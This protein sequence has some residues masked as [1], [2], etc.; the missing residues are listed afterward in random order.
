MWYP[1]SGVVLDCIVSCSLASFLLRY[2]LLARYVPNLPPL[3]KH[4]ECLAH[5]VALLASVKLES[6]FN[7]S[8]EK[9]LIY[10]KDSLIY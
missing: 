2:I 5:I 8:T 10:M 6:P 9:M 1:G 3:F 7:K 4:K